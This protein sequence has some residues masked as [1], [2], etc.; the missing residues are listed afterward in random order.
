MHSVLAA[1]CPYLA[2]ASRQ[3]AAPCRDIVES[4]A[5][6]DNEMVA[7]PDQPGIQNHPYHCGAYSERNHGLYLVLYLSKAARGPENVVVVAAVHHPS[8]FAAAA[9]EEEDSGEE[10]DCET[11]VHPMMHTN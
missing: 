10:E 1:Q 3:S 7:H 11:P 4:A 9:A 5:H 2:F 8:L 6:P